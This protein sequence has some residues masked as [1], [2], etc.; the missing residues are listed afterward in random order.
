VGRPKAACCRRQGVGLETTKR[1]VET[2]AESDRFRLGVVSSAVRFAQN[3]EEN[4]RE[5][6]IDFIPIVTTILAAIFTVILYKRW[7][8]N[9][10][11]FYLGWWTFGCS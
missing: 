5:L 3:L 1:R 9:P 7:R 8:L 4:R 10:Q 11:A 2:D 6:M